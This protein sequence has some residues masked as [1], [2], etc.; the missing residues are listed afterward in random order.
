MNAAAGPALMPTLASTLPGDKR[1][2]WITCCPSSSSSRPGREASAR[3][4]NPSPDHHPGKVRADGLTV[5]TAKR[6][7]IP[8]LP[9][10]ISQRTFFY[11]SS[12]KTSPG[13]GCLPT[14]FNV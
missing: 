1:L 5:S 9:G 6:A 12:S 11:H 7:F 13:P 3:P 4:D 2:P 10:Q 14:I 8:R